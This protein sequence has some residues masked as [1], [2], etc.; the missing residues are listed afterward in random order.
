[1]WPD[2]ATECGFTLITVT[3]SSV[4]SRLTDS[5]GVV[6][7]AGVEDQLAAAFRQIAPTG[8]DVAAVG[9][10]PEH[11]L[12]VAVVRAG[13]S[14]YFALPSDM[15]LFRSWLCDGAARLKNRVSRTE[16]AKREEAKYR[17]EEI[18]GGSSA[19]RSTLEQASRIIPGAEEE[20]ETLRRMLADV[21]GDR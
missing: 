12:A 8:A 7:G 4:L 20:C 18:L 17:F 16:F 3:E 14:E 1:M 9:S 15:E 6:S 21:G 19:L 2:L 5:V 10:V 11:R 13:A